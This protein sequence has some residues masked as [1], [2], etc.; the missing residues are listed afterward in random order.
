MA[1]ILR[2]GCNLFGAFCPKAASGPLCRGQHGDP[3][4]LQRARGHF[5]PRVGICGA[6]HIRVSPQAPSNTWACCITH[7][8]DEERPSV[9]GAVPGSESFQ[10]ERLALGLLALGRGT[11]GRG[12]LFGPEGSGPLPGR[13][14]GRLRHSTSYMKPLTLT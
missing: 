10:V 13:P 14:H 11:V 4:R 1:G 12:D 9:P 6:R 2:L 8:V 3:R 5:L 7:R